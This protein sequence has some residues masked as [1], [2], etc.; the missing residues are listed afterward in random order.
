MKTISAEEFNRRYGTEPTPNR[1]VEAQMAAR[2]AGVGENAATQIKSA[3]TGTGQYQGQNPLTRGIAATKSAL[4]TVP[5]G[6]VAMAPEPVRKG[7]EKV[8][9]VIGG[10]FKALTDLIGSNKQLQEWTQKHPEATKKIMEASQGVADLGAISGTLLGAEGVAGATRLGTRA[11]SGS[12]K[13]AQQS[14]D[15]GLQTLK[16]VKTPEILP[17]SEGIM[18]R[19]ARIPKGAQVKF[20]QS[21]GQSVGEYLTK[22]GIYGNTE[23]ISNQLYKRFTQSK[24]VADNALAQL[25]GEFTSPQIKTALTELEGKVLRTSS[26][27]APDP[28][29][30]RVQ[31]LMQK[32]STTGLTM[33]EINEVKRIFERRV[34]MDFLKTNVPEDVTKAMN[35]DNAIREW[36]FAKAEEL[37]LKNLPEINTETRL[38]KQLLDA[39]GKENAGTM[40]NNAVSLTD[41]ILLSGGDPTAISAYL[42][43]KVFSSKGI[44]S[45]FAEKLYNGNTQGV[46]VRLTGDDAV[47][48]VP[49]TR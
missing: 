23:E 48:S 42:A 45:Y 13:T 41:W 36:Q 44:Q 25:D 19:V 22:R 4:F 47:Q 8:G 33:T 28:D 46:P 15:S 24:E 1:I 3:I 20:E 49:I 12:L 39:I 11:I 30:S 5:E 43:K 26:P 35:I 31:A 29:L 7:L 34:K 27:G 37:G 18:Q 16:T 17:T 21:A 32:E 40:G 2:L 9:D 10:G 38:A 14:I 6:A